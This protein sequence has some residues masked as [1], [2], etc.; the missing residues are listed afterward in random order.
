MSSM[1]HSAEN[2]A[3]ELDG[4]E[5][6]STWKRNP[7]G[8]EVVRVERGWMYG[9]DEDYG[10]TVR[11]H[12]ATGGRPLVAPTEWLRANFTRVTPPVEG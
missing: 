10:P 7:P 3:T 11:A 4:I 6:G 5:V 12:P 1:E 2:D 9:V 8:R